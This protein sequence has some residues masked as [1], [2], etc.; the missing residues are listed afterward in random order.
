[1]DKFHFDE[2]K[3]QF[4]LPNQKTSFQEFFNEQK[5]KSVNNRLEN[6]I[7]DINKTKVFI[8]NNSKIITFIDFKE[9]Y[10]VFICCKEQVLFFLEKF[11]FDKFVVLK[12]GKE[13]GKIPNSLDFDTIKRVENYL[14]EEDF[15]KANE[16][17]KDSDIPLNKLSL[18]YENYQKFSVLSK[19]FRLTS[20]RKEF[21]NKLEKLID[22]NNLIYICGPKS[23]GKTTS[24]LYYLKKY[25]MRHF[26]INLSY[27]KTLF[28]PKDKNEL[29]LAICKELYNCLNFEDVKDAYAFLNEKQYSSIMELVFD[30]LN[31]L[32]KK[33][34]SKEIIIVI[35]QYKEKLDNNNNFMKKIHSLLKISNNLTTIICNSLNEKDFRKSLELYLKDPSNFFLNYLFINKLVSIKENEIN[36]LNREEKELLAKCGNL[37]QYYYE[38][39]EKKEYLQ[40]EDISNNI[41]NEITEEIKGYYNNSNS[42]EIIKKIRDIHDNIEQE[43]PFNKLLD[44][45]KLFP[46]KYFYISINSNNSF[47]ITDIKSTSIIKINSSFPL[48][49]NSINNIL[50]EY[51][52]L[53]KGSNLN[54]FEAQKNSIALEENFN[55]FLWTS[56]FNYFYKEC[57]IKKKLLISS[58]IK[59]KDENEKKKYESMIAE[60]NEK[61]DSILIV[62]QSSNAQYFDTAILKC[63]DK[64]K[65]LFELYLF[66]E[67]IHKRPEDRLCET[68]LNTQKYYLKLLFFVKLNIY[69]NDVFFSYVFK[70]EDPD[71]TTI[72]YCEENQINYIKYFESER[73][74]DAS[75]ID[76][77]IKS[78]FHYLR[79]PKD[80]TKATIH[81]K[82]LDIN[83]SKNQTE[84]E[85]RKL[86]DFLKKK[87]DNKKKKIEEIN[88]KIVN[89][90]SFDNINF[91]KNNYADIF[92]DEEL[93]EDKPVVGISYEID[94]ETKN[95]INELKFTET[96]MNNFFEL[97][98]PFGTNLSFLKITKIDNLCLDWIPSFRSAILVVNTKKA[99]FYYNIGEKIL[100][101]LETKKKVTYLDC[102]SKY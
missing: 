58:I 91:R 22:N 64:E 41:I 26:Y 12:N 45:S 101:N 17:I 62:Q 86:D 49:I 92:L 100:Y 68:L 28:Q 13:V 60:L 81:L 96:Q 8:S 53:E 47:E 42:T 84:Q 34:S 29:C 98:K 18:L 14:K 7:F 70:G 3:K 56:R 30:L 15:N 48:V 97:V 85:F 93:M 31:Y 94:E 44:V 95:N 76:S 89:A 6:N 33:F 21:F 99:K 74:L 77:T 2:A 61:K 90:I 38:I 10:E 19:K 69:I 11:N 63:I 54:N 83:L 55:E 80:M 20:E 16:L 88:Q 67:T 79:Y 40:I 43:I 32:A 27:L 5:K 75:D 59:I 78:V 46:F 25:T 23:I 24:L 4:Y 82:T 65:K 9:N 50:Y 57:K 37:F 51:K 36:S 71:T 87:R 66:Q 102:Q 35:D 72:N 39:N 73:K 1:M 52:G